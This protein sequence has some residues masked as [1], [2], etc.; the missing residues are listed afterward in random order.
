MYRREIRLVA[1]AF[2]TGWALWLALVFGAS[3]AAALALELVPP[4]ILLPLVYIATTERRIDQG[5]KRQS[6]QR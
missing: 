4:A 2:S 6:S 1:L 5:S 3:S